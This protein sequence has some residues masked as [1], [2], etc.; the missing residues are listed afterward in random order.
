MGHNEP[1]RVQFTSLSAVVVMNPL[2]LRFSVVPVTF[3]SLEVLQSLQ[4]HEV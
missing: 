2:S 3:R 4:I 1:V